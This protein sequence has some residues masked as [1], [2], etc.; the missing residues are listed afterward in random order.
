MTERPRVLIA[1]ASVRAMAR[2]AIAAG[3]D[4]LTIDAF[5]DRDLVERLPAPI[6]HYALEPFTARAAA[7]LGA[8]LDADAVAYASGFENDSRAIE[9]LAVGRPIWGC[10]PRAVAGV[11][12]P[13]ALQEALV[14][15]PGCLVPPV[16]VGETPPA[17]RA[18]RFLHK[19]IR[20]GGGRGISLWQGEPVESEHYLQE[21][22][23]GIP[24]SAI[25][26][27]DGKGHCVVLGLSRQLVGEAAFGARGFQYCGSLIGVGAETRVLPDADVAY[28]H[29]LRAA[30]H[31]SRRFEL[32]GLF[33][34]DFVATDEFAAPIEVNPRTSASMELIERHSGSSLFALHVA[35]C[36]GDL[37][38]A[39]E[40][41][42]SSSGIV[43][44]K[45]IV[46]AP[47]DVE[48][49]DTDDW[50]R[51]PSLADIPRSRAIIR[52][53]MPICTV[54]ASSPTGEACRLALAARAA[55]LLSDCSAHAEVSS[56]AR[57]EQ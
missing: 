50:L 30:A 4:V 18:G 13:C 57:R 1:G 27:A 53:G 25:C 17:T 38:P 26:L 45:A 14:A 56:S 12:D 3:Y 40:L 47:S 23:A 32:R 39:L 52:G 16:F 22:V 6:A 21:F 9:M 28:E 11:R 46:Y 19:P 8:T 51:D 41:T 5:A 35:A 34:L 15:Q 24:G 48:M 37:G 10:S 2:S 31:L 42:P 29:A 7:R 49:P 43:L 44:G 20:G 55:E 33:C 54:F 36:G